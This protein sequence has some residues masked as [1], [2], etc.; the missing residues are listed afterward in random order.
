MNGAIQKD[1]TTVEIILGNGEFIMVGD[2]F[3]KYLFCRF[4]NLTP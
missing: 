2:S 4:R 1:L 3:L